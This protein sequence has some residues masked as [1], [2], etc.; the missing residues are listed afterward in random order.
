MIAKCEQCHAVFTWN[1][2]LPSESRFSN[3]SLD[4]RVTFDLSTLYT[5]GEIKI[6]GLASVPEPGT[7]IAV[8]AGASVTL[9]RRR[10]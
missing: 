8:L 4:P 7:W 2:P 1:G 6:G 5:T 3:I 9:V 10:R